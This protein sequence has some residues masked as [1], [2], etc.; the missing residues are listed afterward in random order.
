MDIIYATTGSST[1]NGRA[2]IASVFSEFLLCYFEESGILNL[3]MVY[4][5]LGHFRFLNYIIIVYSKSLIGLMTC[6]LNSSVN[7]AD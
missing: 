5:V 1:F 4:Q 3:L 7:M 2:I 6:S